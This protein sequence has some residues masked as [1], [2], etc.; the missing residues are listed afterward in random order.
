MYES[1]QEGIQNQ[2][3]T[4]DN[5]HNYITHTFF[6]TTILLSHLPQRQ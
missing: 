3:V 4:T 2:L 6:S 1:E 5:Y